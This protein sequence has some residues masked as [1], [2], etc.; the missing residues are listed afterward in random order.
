MTRIVLFLLMTQ[1]GNALAGAQPA[2]TVE[3]LLKKAMEEI[4]QGHHDKADAILDDA[5]KAASNAKD[6]T[7][8]AQVTFQRA[9]NLRDRMNRDN[10]DAATRKRLEEQLKQ[11]Y[12]EVQA[13]QRQGGIEYDKASNNL[14]VMYLQKGEATKAIEEFGKVGNHLGK[15]KYGFYYNFGKALEAAH[16]PEN[17]FEKY[18]LVLEQ[19]PGSYLAAQALAR[20]LVKNPKLPG[21]L[22]QAIKL[23][24]FYDGD[25]KDGRQ[26]LLG[27][28]VYELLAGWDQNRQGELDALLPF[29]AAHLARDGVDQERFRA[30]FGPDKPDKQKPG[31]QLG[32]LRRVSALRGAVEELGFIFLRDR[33]AGETA[34][35]LLSKDEVWSVLPT[36]KRVLDKDSARTTNAIR[37]LLLLAGSSY[38]LAARRAEKPAAAAPARAA[39][40]RFTAAFGLD[41]RAVDPALDAVAILMDYQEALDKD[42]KIVNTFAHSL[43]DQKAEL[44]V[45]ATTRDD[46]ARLQSLHIVLAT[47]FER[48]GR[49]ND[50]DTHF[51]SAVFQ[52]KEAIRDEETLQRLDPTY[53]SAP[54][55]HYRLAQAYVHGMTNS[56]EAG[57]SFLEAANRYLLIGNPQRA[58]QV[59]EEV[60][61]LRATDELHLNE[62]QT[63]AVANL[64]QVAARSQKAELKWDIS[65]P[66]LVR[67]LALVSLAGR[68]ERLI[69]G[70]RD[71]LF[72]LDL[73]SIGPTNVKPVEGYPW[74]GSGL[75]WLPG[76]RKFVRG[77]QAAIEVWDAEFFRP[78]QGMGRH[79]DRVIAIAA[80]SREAGLFVSVA[81]GGEIK[82]WS[83]RDDKEVRAFPGAE[84]AAA[85]RAVLSPDGKWVASGGGRVVLVKEIANGEQVLRQETPA[86]VLSLDISHD[87]QI[88][89][90]GLVQGEVKLY[91][92]R[93]NKPVRTLNVQGGPVLALKFSP[94]GLQFL[95]VDSRAVHLWDARMGSEIA[96]FGS[97]L[98]PLEAC[99]SSDA[100]RLAVGFGR[101]TGKGLVRVWD[102]SK[103]LDE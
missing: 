92:L 46:H 66:G 20:L 37:R 58:S 44:R 12:Q 65:Q 97:Q 31:G 85:R 25:E 61:K 5:M 9:L 27:P 6:P 99:F 86:D 7:L 76:S 29:L 40:E 87:G 33:L 13:N 22:P 49:W 79:E 57:D 16:K 75:A 43:F 38:R 77:E 55:L 21:R 26:Q 48:E 32:Q 54:E 56:T 101:P 18:W 1:L 69:L 102:V 89:A 73:A 39:L 35:P 41:Q 11:L 45:H 28:L 52:W 8:E 62:K 36:W 80:G 67:D 72:A 15:D 95:T 74:S 64:Q 90:V 51:K 4:V 70:G 78:E 23:L 94:R 93:E 2:S 14:G 103:I 42:R 82:V 47:I 10:L 84:K 30:S 91:H 88:L 50:P 59:L 100:R 98:P 96:R 63:P 17:A 60:M 68:P 53:P 34:S 24:R 83:G 3:D 71:R 81:M 19:E